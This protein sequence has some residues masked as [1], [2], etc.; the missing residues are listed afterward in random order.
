MAISAKNGDFDMKCC[1]SFH[2]RRERMK[3]ANVVSGMV[4]N[5]CRKRINSGGVP[6]ITFFVSSL[7]MPLKNNLI[8]PNNFERFRWK[9]ITCRIHMECT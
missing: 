5:L 1:L 8:S 4:E 6:F 7:C 3:W 2:Q 9:L